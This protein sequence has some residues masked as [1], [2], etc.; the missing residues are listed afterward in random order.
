MRT[1]TRTNVFALTTLAAILIACGTPNRERASGQ[2]TDA[3][4]TNLVK[5]SYAYVAMY[6]TLSGFALNEKNPFST[7]GWNKTYKPTALTDHTVTAIAGPNNDTLYVISALD[8]RKE[9]VVISYPAFESKF[10]SLETSAYDHY[11]DIPLSTTKGDFRKPARLLFYSARTEGYK[12]VP[13][14]GVDKVVE[15][16]GD[17]A[18][19]FL[20]VMPQANDPKLFASNMK[21]IQDVKIQ[22]LSEFQGHPA[23]PVDPVQFPAHGTDMGV[24]TGNFLEVMQFAV[25]H[26]TFDAADAM[27]QG[28]LAALKPL[29]VEP[30]KKF[31]P[32]TVAP[33]DKAQIEKVVN[34]VGAEAKANAN[35]YA[36]EKFRPKGQMQLDAMVSQSVTGPVGQPADQAIYLQVDTADGAPMNAQYDYVIRMTK[37][38]LPPARAFWSVTLYD[39]EK[40]LFIP[41][42]RKKYSVGE[43]AGM[44]L[45]AAGGIA[46]YIAAKQPPN[47]PAEDWL[48]IIRKDQPLNTRFR[49]YAP[50]IEK[51]KT[52]Q[53]P[54]AERTGK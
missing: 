21:A 48:P 7:H 50:D 20:R 31:D 47:V 38:Q 24:F 10:V 39:G 40:Y 41:N 13:V 3:E 5:R 52:W 28:V 22:T 9:P 11:C 17:F 25:N 19:A 53:T 36:L 42:D 33:L 8:L 15:M 2:M 1:L 35:K 27:D 4:M 46:I 18:T 34:Q 49:V 32:N 23:K 30:G 16:S 44:K 26:T 37:D 12:G 43:N 51:M 6:N 54:E 29:G 45:D 14:T